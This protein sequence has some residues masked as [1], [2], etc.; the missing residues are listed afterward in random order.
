MA[1]KHE[2]INVSTEGSPS[3]FLEGS[4]VDKPQEAQEI[5]P[6]SPPARWDYE[7]DILIVGGGGAGMCAAAA[8]LKNGAKVLVLEKQARTGGHSQHAGAA[9][10]FNTAAAK[11]RKLNTKSG[12]GFPL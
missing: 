11:R 3:R 10:T 12:R 8:A 7:T 2:A 5:P 6:V 9:A 1:I 4:T